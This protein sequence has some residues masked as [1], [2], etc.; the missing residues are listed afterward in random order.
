MPALISRTRA[1]LVAGVL[2]LHDRPHL[3]VG[4]AQHA[5]VGAGLVEHDREQG[6]RGPALA[7]RLEQR[8]SVSAPQ[9]RQVAVDHQ[10]RPSGWAAKR[11]RATCSAWPVP[12]GGSWRTKRRPR[13]ANAASTASAWWPTTTVTGSTR[14]APRTVRSTCS[15]SGTPS[16]WCSTLARALFMRVPLPGGE[17]DGL[18]REQPCSIDRC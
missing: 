13:P 9:Q 11:S 1:L 7:V 8:S 3:A 5:A 2:R 15:S 17:D 6:G 10:Q 18:Q 14:R 16:T 4:V 12:S